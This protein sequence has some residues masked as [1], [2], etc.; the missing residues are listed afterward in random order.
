MAMEMKMKM[1]PQMQNHWAD[2]HLL[3]LDDD[4]AV[5]KSINRILIQKKVDWHFS[6]ATCVAEALDLMR[7]T[8]FDM[9]I[10]DIKMPGRDG[11]HFLKSLRES[12]D[13]ADLPVIM[14]TGLDSPRIKTKAIEMGAADLLSKPIRPEELLARI[15][16]VLCEK[17]KLDECK[18]HN[19]Y[20]RDLASEH[21]RE[22]ESG[23]IEMIL[24]LAKAADFR[25]NEDGNHVIRVGY[26]AKI[27]SEQ[28]GVDRAFSD[29]LFITSPLHDIGK[30][31]LPDAVL[32]K[33]GKLTEKEWAITKSHCEL[34]HD[35]L[36]PGLLKDR[37]SNQNLSKMVSVVFDI[38]ETTRN[39]LLDMAAE[40]ALAHHEWY[41]GS[42]YPY[43]R[44]GEQ[45]PLAARIVAI[46]DSY[47]ALRTKKNYRPAYEHGQALAMMQ[48]L[49]GTQFD[50]HIFEEFE[51]CA[52]D[53][54]R[55]YLLESF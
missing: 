26:Y 15:H 48:K 29:K 30:I 52:D 28:L 2:Q 21:S 7:K 42:G 50:P 31:A 16:S 55:I 24:R 44:K 3:F 38:Y 45:I 9:L 20:L 40:I 49:S 11:F 19:D 22:I 53:F 4:I 10:T 6:F 8:T 39:H 35:L 27:L 13:W 23:K 41:D 12:P 46:A 17:R 51:K 34:G 14:V 5:L 43:G 25:S 47:D 37:A 54:K 32:M 18:A 33:S 36:S 1:S